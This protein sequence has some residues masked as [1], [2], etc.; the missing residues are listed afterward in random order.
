VIGDYG[1]ISNTPAVTDETAFCNKAAVERSKI[2]SQQSFSYSQP[3]QTASRRA[4]A[5]A[6]TPVPLGRARFLPR[7]HANTPLINVLFPTACFHRTKATL[8]VKR[9]RTPSG[10]TASLSYPVGRYDVAVEH[11][12]FEPLT[13]LAVRQIVGRTRTLDA[14][15][16]VSGGEQHITVSAE[17]ELLDRNSSTV[18]GLIER[19]QANELPLNRRNC[20]SLTAYIPGAIDTGGSNQRSVRF[21]GRGLDDS[22][23]PTMA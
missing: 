16:R 9:R 3:S 23:S 21:A 11:P 18:I 2:T 4:P 22:N 20:A 5:Q 7:S 8:S 1:L 12:D 13:F 15:L 6:S 19:K 14:P 17:S 10:V